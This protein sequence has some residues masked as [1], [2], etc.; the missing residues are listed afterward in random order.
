VQTELCDLLGITL[1][2]DSPFLRGQDEHS[3]AAQ[4]LEE[5]TAYEAEN[6]ALKSL[7]F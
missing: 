1:V 5:L 3:K 7:T 6:S 4:T 2:V